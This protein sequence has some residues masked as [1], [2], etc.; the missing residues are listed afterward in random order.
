MIPHPNLKAWL[1][2]EGNFLDYSGN[3]LSTN[4]SNAPVAT[5]GRIGRGYDFNGTS[6]YAWISDSATIDI[7][8]AQTVAISVKPDRVNTTQTII[9][10]GTVS[11]WSFILQHTASNELMLHIYGNLAGSIRLGRKT[12]AGALSVGVFSHLIMEYDGGTSS[13]GLRIYRDLVQIDTTD[14][15]A[16]TFASRQDGGAEV[17]IAQDN[18]VRFWDGVIDDVQVYNKVLPLSDKQ[19][20]FMGLHPIST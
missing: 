8:G 16:G 3:G 13:S 17:R 2:M 7:L 20:V 11:N 10:K 18:G 9:G 5:T 15:N 1:P 6:Q 4:N 19:R 14:D 12:A